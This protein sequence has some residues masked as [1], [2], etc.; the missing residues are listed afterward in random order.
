MVG[1]FNVR[2]GAGDHDWMAWDNALNGQRGSGY[3][4]NCI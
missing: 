3:E 1:R 4:R 2:S